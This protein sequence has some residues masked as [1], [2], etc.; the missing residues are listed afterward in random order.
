MGKNAQEQLYLLDTSYNN[1]CSFKLVHKHRKNKLNKRD[2]SIPQELT[3]CFKCSL[4][5]SV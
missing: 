2:I 1:C 3:Y 4:N 5:I